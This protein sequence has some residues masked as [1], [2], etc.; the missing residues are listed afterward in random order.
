MKIV[1]CQRVCPEYI[2]PLFRELAR[3]YDI[4]FVF[5]RFGQEH[6]FFFDPARLGD[7]PVRALRPPPFPLRPFRSRALNK[8][9]FWAHILVLGA[10]LA[11][12]LLR[13]RHDVIVGGDF[14]R[15]EAVV[16]CAVARIGR[17]RYVLWSDEWHWPLTWRDRLRL[18]LVRWMVRSSTAL[19]A[20]G[21]KAKEKLVELGAGSRP[22]FNVYHTNVRVKDAPRTPDAERFVLYVGRLEERKGVDVLLRA[23]ADVRRSR[24][25]VR[26]KVL[27]RG[28]LLAPL[29]ALA[30][31]LAI[32]DA[33]DFVGWVDHDAVDDYYRRCAVFVL[34]SRFTPGGGYEPFSNV[35][36]EAMAC[37]APV[38]AT[39]A[40][41]VAFDVVEDGVNGR[42]VPGGDV[43]ALA[44]AL[45]ALL[46][47]PAAAEAMGRRGQAT[48]R[49]RFNVD[50]MAERFGA[51]LDTVFRLATAH[52]SR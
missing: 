30:A 15:F 9:A 13:G 16:A 23:F 11:A 8:L 10:Q 35:V 45:A 49:D 44:S 31:S 4:E 5:S 14:L 28:E 17:R 51:A 20:G 39:T 21:T 19:L 43:A 1:V 2:V 37:G 48:I 22:V 6:A 33:V 52:T 25:G 38:I 47:D 40:N 7:L 41:G 29:Q 12:T 34:P 3:K 26:L 46:D 42:V 36:L 18:P 32:A 50:R 24:P 27:G